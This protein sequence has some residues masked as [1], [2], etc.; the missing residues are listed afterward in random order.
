LADSRDDGLADPPNGVAGEADTPSFIEPP[1]GL[2]KAQVS[3]RDEILQRNAQMTVA[4]G[5][6]DDEAEVG[7]DHTVE[8]TPVTGSDAPRQP[9]LLLWS[10]EGVVADLLKVESEGILWG[11]RAYV[12][13]ARPRVRDGHDRLC[14]R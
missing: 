14:G 10:D 4:P 1:G 9:S 8:R 13:P 6:G 3:L 5:D 11:P 2:E 12:A 7:F